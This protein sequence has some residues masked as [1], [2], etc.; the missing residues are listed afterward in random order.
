M[1][2]L[3]TVTPTNI[4]LASVLFLVKTGLSALWSETASAAL[5]PVVSIFSA[6]T[7]LVKGDTVL[8]RCAFVCIA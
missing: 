5:E 1:A 2:K 6:L 3:K 8:P 7:A 4:D